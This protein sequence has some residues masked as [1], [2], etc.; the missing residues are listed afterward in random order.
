MLKRFYASRSW[1][2]CLLEAHQLGHDLQT[3]SCH[4]LPAASSR[5]VHRISSRYMACKHVQDFPPW[6]HLVKHN[7]CVL[8]LVLSCCSMQRFSSNRPDSAAAVHLESSTPRRHKMSES[9]QAADK[10]EDQEDGIL[11]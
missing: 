11:L 3:V 2:F 5:H 8:E 4:A 1:L 10:L 7:V 9:G 6:Y